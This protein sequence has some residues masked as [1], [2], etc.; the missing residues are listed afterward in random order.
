MEQLHQVRAVFDYTSFLEA[1]TSKKWSFLEAIQSVYSSRRLTSFVSAKVKLSPEERLW[2]NAMHYL[3][4]HYS[5]ELNL[6][7]LLKIAKSEG[8]HELKIMMPYALEE[9][10]LHDIESH[11]ECIVQLIQEMDELKIKL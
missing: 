5:D 2:Q 4:T 8:I 3:S 11:S 1:L 6:L 7:T 9:S 10:Q